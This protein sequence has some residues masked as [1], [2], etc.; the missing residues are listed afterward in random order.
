VLDPGEAEK[1]R[2]DLARLRKELDR[3]GGDDA[4]GALA[5]DKQLLQIVGKRPVLAVIR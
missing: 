5:A 3:R 1:R 2:L 4:E